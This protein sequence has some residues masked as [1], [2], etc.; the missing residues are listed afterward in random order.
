MN[1][2]KQILENELRLDASYSAFLDQDLQ[3]ME[4]ELYRMEYA[5]L[6]ARQWFPMKTD[7][8]AGAETFAYRVLDVFGR[9]EFIASW[10]DELPT[11]ALRAEKRV[12][13]VETIGNGFHYSKQDLRAAAMTGMQLDRELASAQMRAHEELFDT[14]ALLGKPELGFIGLFRHPDVTVLNASVDWDNGATTGVQILADL[15]ALVNQVL[16]QSK[17]RF[18][19][20]QIV[21][22]MSSYLA[23]EAKPMGADYAVATNPLAVFTQTSGGISVDWDR[24]LETASNAGA[25]RA[26]AFLKSPSVAQL[27]Q[28][29]APEIGEPQLQNLVYKRTIES[30]CGGGI[31]RQ[32]LAMAYMDGL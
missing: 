19:V 32:P 13:N 30:R 20:T 16:T 1:K 9:A 11:A 3:A 29:L 5:D 31:L 4:S 23:A 7:V 21:L 10:S 22:P 17:G 28:P 26:V 25:K 6:K 27:V 18:R 14:T 12:G 15:R 8:P 2:N 24:N